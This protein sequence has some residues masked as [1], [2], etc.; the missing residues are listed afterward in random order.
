MLP[1]ASL[2]EQGGVPLRPSIVVGSA[3]IEAGAA[4]P[5]A[6]ISPVTTA[7]LTTPNSPSENFVVGLQ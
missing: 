1:D 6:S 7:S 2:N 5:T 3:S 4:S